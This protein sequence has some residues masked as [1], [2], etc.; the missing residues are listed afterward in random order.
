MDISVRNSLPTAQ[1]GD[2]SVETWL[3]D[4]YRRIEDAESKLMAGSPVWRRDLVAFAEIHCHDASA[5]QNVATGASYVKMTAFT[6]NGSYL[7]CTPDATNDRITITK[8]GRYSLNG[9]V[10]WSCGTNNVT[11]FASI[12]MGD[13]E[14]DNIH[15]TRKIGTAGDVVN[16]ALTGILNVTSVPVD[17]DLRM[18]HDN[19]GTVAATI[20]Y[21]NI[22]VRYLG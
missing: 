19:A 12:F 22:N 13:A 8:I 3:R 10:S 11:W 2:Q 5:A 16:S 20:S 17:I 21:A 9:S 1:F 6:D 14:Q 18:R 4:L 7:N 15:F